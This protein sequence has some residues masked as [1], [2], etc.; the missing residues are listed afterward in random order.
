MKDSWDLMGN[1]SNRKLGNEKTHMK[2]KCTLNYS[3]TEVDVSKKV[4]VETSAKK[5]G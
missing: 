2:S 5:T 1:G 4:F 3:S